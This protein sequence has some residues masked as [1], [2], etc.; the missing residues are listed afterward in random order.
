MGRS[1]PVHVVV[2]E[3]V[4]AQGWSA[5]DLAERLEWHPAKAQRVLRGDTSLLAE[6]MI[7]IAR[8]MKKPV[9][10]LFESPKSAA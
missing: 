3:H 7:A 6:D 1:K 9:A 8:V 4:A 2:G 5:T 10:E